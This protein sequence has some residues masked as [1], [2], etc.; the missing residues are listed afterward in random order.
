MALYEEFEPRPN[1]L[2]D[3]QSAYLRSA[4]YQPVGW[5]EFGPEAFAEAQRA[6]KPIFLDIGAS[7]VIGAH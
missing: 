2:I 1:R 5:Y 4:A 6:D 3:A 7:C